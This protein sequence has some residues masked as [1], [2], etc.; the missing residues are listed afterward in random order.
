L[1]VSTTT[2]AYSVTLQAKFVMVVCPKRK[3]SRH[4]DGEVPWARKSVSCL[5]GEVAVMDTATTRTHVRLHPLRV[6][7]TL[8]RDELA[9]IAASSS[10]F[11]VGEMGAVVSLVP[12]VVELPAVRFRSPMGVGVGTG[13]AVGDGDG[14]GVGL[15]VGDGDGGGVGLFVGDGGDVG[16]DVPQ[17]RSAS[18]PLPSAYWASPGRAPVKAGTAHAVAASL[19]L[20][21]PAT[22]VG[23]CAIGN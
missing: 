6:G 20:P 2:F 15:F 5:K 17:T 8:A 23:A 13:L 9:S 22:Q 18:K 3:V 11:A 4:D 12:L 16:A 10:A 19:A 1:A 7:T 14:G 21:A